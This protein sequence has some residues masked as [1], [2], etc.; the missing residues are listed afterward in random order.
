MKHVIV[1]KVLAYTTS[2]TT[3]LRSKGIDAVKAYK[4]VHVVIG[5][6]KHVRMNLNEFH[7]DCLVCACDLARR[8]YVKGKKPR[9]CRKQQFKQNAV[10]PVESNDKVATVLHYHIT[11]TA[12]F[13]D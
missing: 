7:H 6:L 4:E 9:T 1:Q 3:R 11:V 8:I 2:L 12:T 13:L 5:T 10:I